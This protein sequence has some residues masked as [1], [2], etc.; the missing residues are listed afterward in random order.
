MS[1]ANESDSIDF[2][3]GKRLGAVVFVADYLQLDFHEARF[4]SF[5]W[6]I[7]GTRCGR[8]E[9]STPGYRDLLCTQIGNSVLNAYKVP[10]TKLLIE[11]EELKIEISL[12]LEEQVG[13]EAAMLSYL[14]ESKQRLAVWRAADEC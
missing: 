3:R 8:L 6:P 7:L 9:I 4:T 12:K 5:L 13:P 1:L 10:K 2:L 14:W 11:F